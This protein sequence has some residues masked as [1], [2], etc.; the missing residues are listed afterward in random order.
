RRC[1]RFL[2]PQRRAGTARTSRSRS[3]LVFSEGGS[4]ANP[5]NTA[6]PCAD[7]GQLRQLADQSRDSSSASRPGCR[8]SKRC[9]SR[10]R[11]A[12]YAEQVRHLVTRL[13]AALAFLALIS[14]AAAQT[15][16][17]SFPNT[18]SGGLYAWPWVL[19]TSSV[20]VLPANPLRKQIVF[21]NP[22]ATATVAVCPA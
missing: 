15:V 3:S 20:Q 9:P 12:A 4:H 10:C 17:F 14:A 21:I 2:R 5:I 18:S 19:S 7:S 1:S 8:N 22:S 11:C 16:P 6:G 13:L